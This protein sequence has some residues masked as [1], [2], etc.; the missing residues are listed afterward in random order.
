M[1]I[2]GQNILNMAFGAIARQTVM[3]YQY[4]SRT[5]NDVGQDVTSYLTAVSI[6]G[7]WQP[8]PRN[9]Y[10]VYGL[11]MQKDYFTFYTS[12]DVLDLQRDVSG[13]QIVFGGDKYQ[14]QSNNDWYKIDGW[15]AILCVRIGAQ[16]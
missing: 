4:D 8:V 5:L 11:D 14:C 12:N 10:R 3:Y 7:S 1:I 13:D 6:T 16:P 15:K 9:L 2:P